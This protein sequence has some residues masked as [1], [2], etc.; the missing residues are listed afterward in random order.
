MPM[1]RVGMQ[2]VTLCVTSSYCQRA[3]RIGRRA[4]RKAFPRG[5]WER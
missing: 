5:A 2:F 1:L 4:S 3:F